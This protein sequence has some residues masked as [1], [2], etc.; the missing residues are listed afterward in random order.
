MSHGIEGS[1][2]STGG[3]SYNPV[4]VFNQPLCHKRDSDRPKEL[5]K[6]SLPSE[7]NWKSHKVKGARLLAL[8]SQYD[9]GRALQHTT[10]AVFELYITNYYHAPL[11]HF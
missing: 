8:S 9:G 4:R 10:A 1:F 5:G 7:R 6:K 2:Q 11:S 3:L